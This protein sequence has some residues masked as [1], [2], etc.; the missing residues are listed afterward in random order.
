MINM[1]LST[2]VC[3]GRNCENMHGRTSIFEISFNKQVISNAKILSL[4]E[5]TQ[6]LDKKKNRVCLKDAR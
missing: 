5:I 6:L 3:P 2:F 1:L 4:N